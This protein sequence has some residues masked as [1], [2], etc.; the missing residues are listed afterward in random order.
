MGLGGDLGLNKSLEKL[1]RLYTHI[2]Y[3]PKDF[4][5]GSRSTMGGLVRGGPPRRGSGGAEALRT[6]DKF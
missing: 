1:G 2:H 5:G 4:F 3:R 6:P